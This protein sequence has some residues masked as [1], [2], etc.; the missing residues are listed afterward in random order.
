MSNMSGSVRMKLGNSIEMN[1][2]GPEYSLGPMFSICKAWRVFKSQGVRRVE[3]KPHPLL[4]SILHPENLSSPRRAGVAPSR[5]PLGC[6]MPS[7]LSM[8]SGVLL[9]C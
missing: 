1:K 6:H 2:V 8:K 7:S 4:G 5:G 3:T 9:G